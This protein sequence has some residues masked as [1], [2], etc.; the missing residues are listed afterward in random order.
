MSKPSLKTRQIHRFLIFIITPLLLTGCMSIHEAARRGNVAEVKRQLAWGANPNTRTLAYRVAPLHEAAAFGNVKIVEILLEKR[1]KVNITNE[2]GETPLHYATRHGHIK[3][4][5]ILLENN[6]DPSMKGTGC[7]TPMQWAA[8][9]GQI[10][11]IETLLDFGVSVNQTGTGGRTAL[12]EAVSHEDMEMVTFLLANG[13]DVNVTTSLGGGCSPL[14]IAARRDNVQIGRTLL[15]HGADP[16]Y[17]CE[18][19]AISQSFIE[20]LRK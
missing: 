14:H 7:G 13:A 18:G 15:E 4:M 20:K 2:G 16:N 6:A 12:M 19:Q 8:R 10:R 3:V 9:N 1:A 11:P 17:I 5:E